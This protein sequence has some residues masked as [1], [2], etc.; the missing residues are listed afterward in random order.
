M[1]GGFAN[2]GGSW[3]CKF[4]LLLNGL[5]KLAFGMFWA[6]AN[7]NWCGS[8]RFNKWCCWPKLMNGFGGIRGWL[9]SWIVAIFL[10][11][12]SVVMGGGCCIPSG[13]DR[14][15]CRGGGAGGIFRFW[16][17]ICEPL[18]CGLI[19]MRGFINDIAGMPFIRCSCAAGSFVEGFWLN[20]GIV[21]LLK[22]FCAVCWNRA[23]FLDETFRQRNLNLLE[24]A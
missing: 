9:V 8:V 5:F 10:S 22:N 6:L 14:K 23:K 20:F 21:L 7:T 13:S 18:T 15:M 4:I 24:I 3:W 11:G 2:L 16:W 12:V 19:S 17:F 1:V